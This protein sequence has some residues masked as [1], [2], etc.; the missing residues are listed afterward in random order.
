MKHP[1]ISADGGKVFILYPTER[2][3]RV[4]PFSPLPE[5]LKNRVADFDEG[6]LDGFLTYTTLPQGNLLSRN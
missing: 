5:G 2:F 1:L 6:L 3:M 4:S